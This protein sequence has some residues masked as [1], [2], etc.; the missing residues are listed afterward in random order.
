MFETPEE[1]SILP[2]GILVV[3]SHVKR[4]IECSP[5]GAAGGVT[6]SN[7]RGGRG[8]KWPPGWV[9]PRGTQGKGSCPGGW[10][11]PGRH[12]ASGGGFPFLLVLGPRIRARLAGAF[13]VAPAHVL[14]H[15]VA[16][17]HNLARLRSAHR[18]ALHIA[19]LGLAY[20]RSWEF[21]GA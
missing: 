1:E 9:Y 19:Q 16:A 10:A 14:G 17:E 6:D 13:V 12:S 5:E 15:L 20:L 2:W 21:P 4:Q 11:R 18:L 8:L 3:L 7:T